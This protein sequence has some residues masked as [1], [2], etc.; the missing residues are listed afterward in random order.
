MEPRFRAFILQQVRVVRA[1]ESRADDV[2]FAELVD[3][4]A[5]N[6]AADF[7]GFD[8]AGFLSRGQVNL[9][10][11]AGDDGFGI[12]TEARQKHLHLF[13]GG[14]LRFIENYEGIIQRAPAH[15]GERRNFD[16]SLFQE[17]FELIGIEHVVERVVERA[18]VG[19][20][21]LLQGA[22]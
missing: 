7:H 10:D 15:E 16:N 21:F 5:G 20:D 4:D 13:A 18:H 14:I 2:F 1:W 22:G 3:A 8:E 19:I 6:A 17:A 9:G 11:V 12:E